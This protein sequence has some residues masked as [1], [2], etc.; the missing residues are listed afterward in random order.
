MSDRGSQYPHQVTQTT[1]S[2]GR[3]GERDQTGGLGVLGSN[4]AA[5]TNKINRL[6]RRQLRHDTGLLADPACN[7]SREAFCAGEALRATW[8]RAIEE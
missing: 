4:P 8:N 2:Y 5:P 3:I 6:P 7:R 1:F